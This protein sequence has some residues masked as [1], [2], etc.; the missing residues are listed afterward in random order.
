MFLQ[1]A[2]ASQVVFELLSGPAIDL[3]DGNTVSQGLAI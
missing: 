3:C 1:S 2:R